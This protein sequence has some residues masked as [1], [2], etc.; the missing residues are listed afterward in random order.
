MLSA[1]KQVELKA[2]EMQT[3]P[4]RGLDKRVVDSRDQIKTFYADRIPANYSSFAIPHRRSAGQVGC[5][6]TRIS[7]PRAN[8]GPI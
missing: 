3:A 8:P 5:T 1:S 7:T 4:L 6:S 2:L